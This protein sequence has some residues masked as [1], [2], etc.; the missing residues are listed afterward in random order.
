[1][2]NFN[3]EN[4]FLIESAFNCTDYDVDT[5]NK[6]VRLELQ[7]SMADDYIKYDIFLKIRDISSI[8]TLKKLGEES[9][10]DFIL[11]LCGM[12]LNNEVERVMADCE[13]YAE[14]CK[15]E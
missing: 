14:Y 1:M 7:G 6:I 3:K 11:Y 4:K 10:H 13:Y 5:K 15:D 2:R 8:D 9:E 12:I